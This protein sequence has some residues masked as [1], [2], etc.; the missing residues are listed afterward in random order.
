MSLPAHHKETGRGWQGEKQ[1]AG[2]GSRTQEAGAG[3]R[4]RSR[5]QVQEQEAGAGAGGRCRMRALRNNQTRLDPWFSA[6]RLFLRPAPA[7]CLL[8]LRPALPAPPAPASYR[9]LFSM[10]V[11]STSFIAARASRLGISETLKFLS[12]VDELPLIIAEPSRTQPLPKSA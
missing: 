6:S 2:A 5:R 7:S 1:E 8:L 3:G 12:S 9:L 10:L 4:C 11:A